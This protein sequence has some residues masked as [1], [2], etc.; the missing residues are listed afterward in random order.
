MCLKPVVAKKD[1]S[2]TTLLLSCGAKLASINGPSR[3][4]IDFTPL[5]LFDGV[6]I[7]AGSMILHLQPSQVIELL[8]LIKDDKTY[9][10]VPTGKRGRNQEA[11]I[12]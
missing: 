5:L 10:R 2:K 7:T 9:P 6:L 4:L 8:H 11:G 12:T 3:L 1:F